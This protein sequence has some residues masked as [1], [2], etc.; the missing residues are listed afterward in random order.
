[1]KDSNTTE[2]RS[3]DL[4]FSLLWPRG[5]RTATVEIREQSVLDLGLQKLIEF[6]AF[7][8]KHCDALR[9]I[10]RS[11]CQDADTINYRLDIID[12]LARFPKLV[13][14]IES[15]LPVLRDLKYYETFLALEWKTSLQ[16]TIWRLREL[17][18]YVDCL[19]KLAAA[20]KG[21]RGELRSEA[22]RDLSDL[23][24]RVQGDPVFQRLVVALPDLLCRIRSLKSITIGVNLDA[25]MMP[26]E[27]TLVSINSDEYRESPFFKSLFGADKWQGIGTLHKAPERSIATG[28]M[29]VSLFQDIS[30]IMEKTTQPLAKALKE[31]VSIN[32]RVL[33][34]L[35]GD[36]LFYLGAIKLIDAMKR[37]GLPVARPQVL[38]REKRQLDVKDIYNVDLALHLLV[39]NG[40]KPRDLSNEIVTNDFGQDQKGRIVIITG[41]NRGGKT[42]L[43]QAIGLAQIMMQVGLY[44][45]AREAAMSICDGILTHYPALERLEKG[46]GRF[47]E[48]AQ[49]IGSLFESATRHSLVLLNE[50]LSS[51]SGGESLY[52][53]RD[54]VRVLR[55]L[56][57]RA[58]YATHLHELAAS[59]AQLNRDTRGDSRVLSVV[60]L[61]EAQSGAGEQTAIKPTFKIVPGPPEGHSY[62]IDLAR[63]YGI[64]RDQLIAALEQRGALA[65]SS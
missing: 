21:I 13:R 50:S 7:N 51:T 61:I 14:C 48:E 45:P 2:R 9:E 56:G 19:S 10:V 39:Q 37:C 42:T 30:K 24:L 46:T 63:R 11:L 33:T 20:F 32:T 49:R 16:E 28:P 8:A 6:M 4:S 59:A 65:A 22:L 18:H 41:P 47:G 26:C 38:T 54:I 5:T 57:S 29:M 12:E 1:M 23:V 25:G 53:A 58:V 17:E 40:G 44:V 52:L 60:A 55:M 15:L 36:F 62:A 34:H 3:P 43:L 31:F 64:S 27:A 35:H